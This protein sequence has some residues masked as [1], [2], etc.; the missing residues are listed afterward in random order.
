M[1]D[2]VRVIEGT[3][4]V[5][6]LEMWRGLN[7]EHTALIKMI[8]KYL[9]EFS[10]IRTISFLNAKSTGGRPAEYAML[11]EEQ[12][13]FLITLMRNSASTVPFKLKLT[14]EFYRM[15]QELSRIASQSQNAQWLE[16][17]QTGK[18]IRYLATDSIKTFVD[19]AKGQG[20]TKA[21][22]YYANISKMQN[23]ALFFLEQKFKNLR[24]VLNINQL[25]TV[26]CADQIV[27]KALNDGMAEKMYYRDIYLLAK[28]RVTSFSEVIGKTLIPEAQLQIED[29]TTARKPL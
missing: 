1:A 26:K 2:M 19:Y 16:M 25:S 18:E 15:K 3:P 24:D 27:I 6:T 13:T 21:E 7:V 23:S 11:D 20:S 10:T 17:R 8:K 5:S 9:A 22:M 12:A 28:T 14:R 4:L 29:K